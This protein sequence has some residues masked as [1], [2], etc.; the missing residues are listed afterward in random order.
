VYLLDG[1]TI[2]GMAADMAQ[3]YGYYGDS[4]SAYIVGIGY[5]AADY[6][7]W[8]RRRSHDYVHHHLSSIFPSYETTGGGGSFQKFVVEE[9]RPLIAERYPVDP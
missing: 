5:P 1:N 2:F 8:T 9:L 6:A 4:E 7:Q 3:G